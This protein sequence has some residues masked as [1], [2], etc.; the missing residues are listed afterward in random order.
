VVTLWAP[1]CQPCA[2][3]LPLFERL[4][5]AAAG[6]LTVI[7]VVVQAPAGQ[8]VAAGRDVG[9][10]FA[11]LYDRDGAVPAGLG[12]VALPVTVLVGPEGRVRVVHAAVLPDDA[13]LRTLV[14]RH[15]GV[16]VQ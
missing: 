15:L 7:G 4:S 3:E 12:K 13:A 1:W 14:A 16:I 6:R 5:Q 2:K 10:T 8:S 11:N 9:V